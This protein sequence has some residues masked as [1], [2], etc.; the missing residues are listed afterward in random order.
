MSADDRPGFAIDRIGRN[1]RHRD[2]QVLVSEPIEARRF[3]DWTM[4]YEPNPEDPR[5]R[6][7]PRQ[8]R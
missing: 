6:G 7:V 1:P 5:P 4:G 2:V 8:L 3:A